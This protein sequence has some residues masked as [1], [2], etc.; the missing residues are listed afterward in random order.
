MMDIPYIFIP[1]DWP[2]TFY[3]GPNW[4][5]DSIFRDMTVAELGCG[6]GWISISLAEKRRPWKVDTSCSVDIYLIS[7]VG[8]M[9]SVQVRHLLWLLDMK[10][11]AVCVLGWD[12]GAPYP[13]SSTGRVVLHPCGSA[14]GTAQP[15][16]SA[17]TTWLAAPPHGQPGA[18]VPK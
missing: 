5:A 13:R 18:A 6:N 15:R 7:F 2:F 14:R 3:E 16:D 1:E 11:L 4:H 10:L 12:R 17:N 9:G 8:N